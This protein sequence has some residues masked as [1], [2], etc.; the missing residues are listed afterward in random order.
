MTRINADIDPYYLCDQ[1]LIAEY[2]EIVR[3]P[4][5]VRK[6]IYKNSTR[7]LPKHFKLGSGHVLYFYNKIK[8]LHKR[9][10]KLRN[11]MRKRKIVCNLGDDMFLYDDLKPF[12]N[13]IHSNELLDG[14]IEVCERIVER[15]ETTKKQTTY[16]GKKISKQDY[17]KIITNEY[18]KRN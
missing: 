12:Y 10:N 13:D 1:H 2:R 6:D 8:F 17:I 5:C 9:F 15:I 14:N 16:Y 3:I 18:F 11:E 7:E 4:N